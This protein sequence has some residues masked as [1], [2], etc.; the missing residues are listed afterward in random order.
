VR[1]APLN[2]AGPQGSNSSPSQAANLTTD[3]GTAGRVYMLTYEGADAAGNTAQC[4]TTVTVPH[5]K[6]K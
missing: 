5:D 3:S 4:S 6:G 1:T 2:G